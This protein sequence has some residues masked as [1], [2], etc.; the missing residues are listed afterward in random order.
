MHITAG[1]QLVKYV[2]YFFFIFR[3]FQTPDIQYLTLKSEALPAC[4]CF[5]SF[6]MNEY[7]IFQLCHFLKNI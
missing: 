6:L 3:I 7:F 4:L 1:D 5:C 2:L